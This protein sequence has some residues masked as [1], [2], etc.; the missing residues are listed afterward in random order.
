[1]AQV[2][3][4]DL[5]EDSPTRSQTDVHYLGDHNRQLLVIPTGVAHGWPERIGSA[6][7]HDLPT[8]SA[9]SMSATLTR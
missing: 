3:L 1:M 8:A 2:V 6:V 9:A 7:T 5:R 4:H